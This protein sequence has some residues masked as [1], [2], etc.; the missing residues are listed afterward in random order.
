MGSNVV[1]V[2]RPWIGLDVSIY[3]ETPNLNNRQMSCFQAHRAF[4]EQPKQYE[5]K[6]TSYDGGLSH[7]SRMLGKGRNDRQGPPAVRTCQLH[8]LWRRDTEDWS[9]LHI[10]LNR[11]L[12]SCSLKW[13]FASEDRTDR[14]DTRS[15][16]LD[17]ELAVPRS[18]GG[19]GIARRSLCLYRITTRDESSDWNIPDCKPLWVP[20]VYPHSHLRHELK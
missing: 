8:S 14:D 11:T 10:S 4:I 1:S 13:R 7:Q 12:D 2:N 15:T 9:T 18:R 3:H 17:R 5:S 16:R 6:H 20:K 19:H